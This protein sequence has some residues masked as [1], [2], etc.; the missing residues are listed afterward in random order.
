MVNSLPTL[1][2]SVL[3]LISH[4]QD[5]LFSTSRAPQCHGTSVAQADQ[6]SV[7]FPANVAQTVDVAREDGLVECLGLR[8]WDFWERVIERPGTHCLCLPDKTTEG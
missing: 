2:K 6:S 3:A 5:V 8:K 7:T 4:E 1:Q